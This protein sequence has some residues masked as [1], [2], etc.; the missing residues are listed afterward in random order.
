M[1]GAIGRRVRVGGFKGTFSVTDVTEG[2][3]G[4]LY[5]VARKMRSGGYVRTAVFKDQLK[6]VRGDF[7]HKGPRK[8]RLMRGLIEKF[9]APTVARLRR[10]IRAELRR[11]GA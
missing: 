3:R 6:F 2:K 8:T 1:R 11:Q 5:F 10:E 4:R 9:G 7:E